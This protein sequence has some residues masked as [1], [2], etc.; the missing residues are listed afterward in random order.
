[1]SVFLGAWPRAQHSANLMEKKKNKP[2][3]FLEEMLE[4]ATGWQH[5]TGPRLGLQQPGP[6]R[7]ELGWGVSKSLLELELLGPGSRRG[8]EKLLGQ[9]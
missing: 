4:A 9:T 8:G 2:S 3:F 1:M 7:R 5:A 6:A